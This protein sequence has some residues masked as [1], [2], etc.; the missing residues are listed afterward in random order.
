MPIDPGQAL[1]HELGEGQY[2]GE[3]ALINDKPRNA[4]IIATDKCTFYTLGQEDFKAVLQ[5]SKSFEAELRNVL[6]SRT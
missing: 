5:M 1:G 3:A 4:T 2:F 6:A